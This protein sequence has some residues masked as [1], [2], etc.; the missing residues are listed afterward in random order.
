MTPTF[1]PLRE[2][3]YTWIGKQ[4]QIAIQIVALLSTDD[5]SYPLRLEALDRAWDVWI[6]SEETDTN[7]INGYLNAFGIA[8]GHLLV[9]SGIFDWCIV[10]DEWGTDLGVRALPSRGDVSIVPVNFVAKRWEKHERCFMAAG[11]ASIIKHVEKIRREW[12]AAD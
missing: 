1:E 10:T 2:S 9:E 4:L 6:A 8:F 12:N 3:E 7:L 5:A 11:Y